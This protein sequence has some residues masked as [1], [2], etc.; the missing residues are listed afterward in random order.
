MSPE[1]YKHPILWIVSE[2]CHYFGLTAAALVVPVV[3]LILWMMSLVDKAAPN[4]RYILIA[5]ALSALM[6]LCGIA[7]KRSITKR[8]Q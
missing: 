1:P 8:E 5:W 3:A 2:A 6:F 7:I 4:Y